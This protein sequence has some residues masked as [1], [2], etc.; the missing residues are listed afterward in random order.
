M[1]NPDLCS[2]KIRKRKLLKSANILMCKQKQF[3]THKEERREK[4][5][6]SE[7]LGKI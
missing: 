1:E 5:H 4:K 3:S 6:E 7:N 2:L